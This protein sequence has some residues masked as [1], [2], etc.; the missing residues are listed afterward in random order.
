MS[1]QPFTVEGI[2]IPANLKAS[3]DRY[4][5]EHRGT[6]RFLRSV[7]E[8][9]LQEAVVRADAE[10]FRCL[11]VIVAYVYNELPEPCWGTKKKVAAWLERKPK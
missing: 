3:L 6:G 2:E 8:N 1:T 4:A 9:D 11:K 10:S 5:S 7:L